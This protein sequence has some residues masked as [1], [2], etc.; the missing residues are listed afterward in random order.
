MNVRKAEGALC[1]D[2]ANQTN[3]PASA[4]QKQHHPSGKGGQQYGVQAA[5]NV[6]SLADWIDTFAEIA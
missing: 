4:L 3:G 5:M 6:A 2:V 1:C